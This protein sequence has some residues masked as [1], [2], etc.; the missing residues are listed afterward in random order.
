MRDEITTLLEVAGFACLVAGAAFL[1]GLGT[2]L[3]VAG[4][5]LLIIGYLAGRG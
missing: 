4:F 3:V 2:A 1:A 5:S